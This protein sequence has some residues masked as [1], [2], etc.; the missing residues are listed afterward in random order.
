MLYWKSYFLSRK[1]GRIRQH[2][3]T[4]HVFNG[5]IRWVNKTQTRHVWVHFFQKEVVGNCTG[6][7]WEQEHG[8]F[9]LVSSVLG[10]CFWLLP[11]AEPCTNRSSASAL[12]GHSHPLTPLSWVGSK[13]NALQISD[14]VFIYMAIPILLHPCLRWA[15]NKMPW[16]YLT[17]SL[18]IWPFPCSYIPVLS[19]QQ[20]KCPANVW[21]CLYLKHLFPSRPAKVTWTV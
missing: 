8:K 15:A 7:R 2:T 5:K 21:P 9:V 10:V 12:Y 17:M 1:N 11:E 14:H 20:T 13:Q 16:K 3:Q 4:V 19:G 18:S 6:G